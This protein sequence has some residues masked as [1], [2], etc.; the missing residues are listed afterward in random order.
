MIL[1]IILYGL[2]LGAIY[3]LIAITY[4][5]AYSS[6]RVMSFTAGAI[7]MLG[8]VFGAAFMSDLGWGTI[9]SLV[10]TLAVCAAIGVLVELIAV[11]PVLDKLEQHLYIL[12][13]LA[14]AII[15]QQGTALFYSSEPQPFPRLPE[16]GDWPVLQRFWL[17]VA[18]LAVVFVALQL[19]YKHTTMG[20][21]FLAVAEDNYAARALGLPEARLR[22][23]SFAMGGAIAGLA[24]F[25]GGQL[26]LAYFGNVHLLIFYGF[27]PVA[28]GSVG[29]NK[30][31]LIMGLV[32]GLF[33]QTAN[34]L[35]G[36]VFA[37]VVVFAAFIAA[38]LIVPDG[39]FGNR[40]ERRV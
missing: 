6:S 27:I 15:V 20:R 36:G 31:A 30:G 38:M 1:S 39:L 32:L 24:G 2:S 18:S 3:A 16:F 17:P 19:I 4:N 7:G 34:F 33:Q 13:T 35:F 8:G 21:A 40:Y 25:S 5:V 9:P 12:S 23:I 11:R 28:L 22:M 37:S 26:L 10:A 14:V 29:S